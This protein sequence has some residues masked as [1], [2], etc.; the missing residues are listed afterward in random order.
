[1]SADGRPRATLERRPEPG[2][3][4]AEAI[5]AARASQARKRRALP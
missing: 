4:V 3:E 5:E 1:V 2:F